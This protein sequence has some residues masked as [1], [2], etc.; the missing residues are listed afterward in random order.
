MKDS[1]HGGWDTGG[2]PRNL[3]AHLLKARPDDGDPVL[4]GGD[5]VRMAD[6]QDDFSHGHCCVNIHSLFFHF[7]HEFLN[8]QDLKP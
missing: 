5:A 2:L 4:D 1:L 7:L 3:G 6:R 8:K